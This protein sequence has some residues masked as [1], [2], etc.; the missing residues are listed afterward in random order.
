MD[1]NNLDTTLPLPIPS[2][3][4]AHSEGRIAE[5]T[6]SQTGHRVSA[7]SRW[8]VAQPIPELIHEELNEYSPLLRQLLYNRGIKDAGTARAFVSGSPPTDTNPLLIKDMEKAV[9]LLHQ[10]V[11][12]GQSAPHGVQSAPHGVQ[13]AP[14]GVQSAH[15][16]GTH[17]RRHAERSGVQSIAVYGDYDADGVT[18]SALMFEFLSALGARPRVY[19]PNRFDEGYGLNLEAIEQLAAEGIDLIIS[20]DCGARSIAEVQRAKDLGMHVIL[21]DH[22]LP[23]ETLP[24]ADAIINPRQEGDSYPEKMLAGVGLAYKLAQGYLLT[25]P[26]EGVAAESWLDLVAIGTVADLAPLT[27]EN[28]ALTRAGLACI[29]RQANRQGLYSLAQVAG[30]NLANITTGNIGFVI[31]PRLNAAGRIETAQT[32]FDL[33]VTKDPITAGQLAQKIEVQNAE[34]Q[35][36]TH[37]IREQ[38]TA[39]ALARNP[40]AYIIFAASPTFSEGVVGLAASRIAETFYR[41]AIIGHQDEA[42]TVASCR[43]IAEFNITQALD[44]C[45]DLLVRYGGHSAAAGLTVEN[46]NLEKLLSRLEAIAAHELKDLE[47][48][49]ILKIDREMQ[50]DRLES[51]QIP[52]IFNDLAV[53]EPTGNSNPEAVF[54]SYNCK[55]AQARAVG[56]QSMHLKLRI[57]A[58]KNEFDAIA[59]RQGHWLDAMPEKI[60]IAY[61]FE[62]NEYMGRKSIQLNIKDI[63]PSREG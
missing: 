1:S 45:A 56:N 48:A 2:P 59:F 16:T 38:A 3:V 17:R 31:G 6:Q 55:V 8:N 46:E 28:R 61:T 36:M 30:L 51:R 25:H 26:V 63:K 4:G 10:A 20:V 23:G 32:A 22:H 58:G 7:A 49:S 12:D 40:Q 27:G 5:G 57:R 54:C 47:L 14:H 37:E 21:T 29:R 41:P 13:S 24:P 53:L 35:A 9:E 39:M 34:R 33:L 42:R 52:E 11:S 60:D 62:V 18:A 44:Q 43:S 19:I 15:P 50:L